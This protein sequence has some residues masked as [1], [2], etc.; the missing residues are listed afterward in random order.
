MDRL[1]PK[2][3]VDAPP[4]LTP[5]CMQVLDEVLRLGALSVR[6]N[7]DDASLHRWRTWAAAGG[8]KELKPQHAWVQRM[9]PHHVEAME[10]L[11][12]T[13]RIPDYGVTIVGSGG[14]GVPAFNI[15]L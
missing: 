3:E 5:A 12:F 9:Q 8:S 2:L 10:A 6:G 14:G 15:P 4:A 1:S 11:P 7:H 13:I